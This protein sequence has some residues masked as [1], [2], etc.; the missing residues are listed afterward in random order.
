MA[1]LSR[2]SPIEKHHSEGSD[3]SSLMSRLRQPSGQ[4][5][6]PPGDPTGSRVP[7]FLSAWTAPDFHAAHN[8]LI[9]AQV[10]FAGLPARVRSRFNN[11][12]YQL[13]R[14]VEDPQN[15]AEAVLLGLAEPTYEEVQI[16]RRAA[17]KGQ[18]VEQ[19]DIVREI[20]AEQARAER[21]RQAEEDPPP[22]PR[23]S[24]GQHTED[25]PE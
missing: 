8:K 22:S 3:P 13:L 19:T 17:R 2:N 6:S 11:E 7:Q 9:E 25:P 12:P 18:L 15:H 20:Q 21:V 16:M 4:Y 1:R 10:Q 23:R 14:F 5:V 24:R